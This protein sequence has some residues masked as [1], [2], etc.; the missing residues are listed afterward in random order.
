VSWRL[1]TKAFGAPVCRSDALRA[2]AFAG[3][4]GGGDVV[5]GELG[6]DRGGGAE[7][8]EAAD[9]GVVAAG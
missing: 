4:L 2:E 6:L 7:R 9:E 8:G 1:T 5:G 3:V